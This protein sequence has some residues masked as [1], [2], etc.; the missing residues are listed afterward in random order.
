MQKN[1]TLIEDMVTLGGNILGS[2]LGARH[3]MK[4]QAKQRIDNVMRQLDLVTREEFD[5]AFTMLSKA[6]L[7]QEELNTRLKLIEDH[8]KLSSIK[9][10]PK[11]KKG[12]LGSNVE[13]PKAKLSLEKEKKRFRQLCQGF[14]S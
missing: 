6:R 9:A 7:L 5:A 4:A 11:A 12:S 14:R 2:L 3:E 13:G 1:H 10:R 8:L